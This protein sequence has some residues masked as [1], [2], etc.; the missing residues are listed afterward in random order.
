MPF[1]PLLNAGRRLRDID[2]GNALLPVSESYM[3]TLT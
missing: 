1:V 2:T 3:N